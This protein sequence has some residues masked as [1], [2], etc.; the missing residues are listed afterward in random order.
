MSVIQLDNEIANKI[1]ES[2][3]P[4]LLMFLNLEGRS[5][6]ISNNEERIQR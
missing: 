3:E 1:V 5:S 2:E 6:E 4:V